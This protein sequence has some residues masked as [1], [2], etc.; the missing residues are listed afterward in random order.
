MKS[1]ARCWYQVHEWH[2]SLQELLVLIHTGMD[3]GAAD[4]VKPAA[5]GK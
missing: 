1:S 3:S 2:G 4:W 5:A